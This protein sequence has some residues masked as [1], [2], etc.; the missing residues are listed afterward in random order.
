MLPVLKA[1]GSISCQAQSAKPLKRYGGLGKRALPIKLDVGDEQ[2]VEQMV[3]QTLETFGRIDVLVNN[4]AIAF[5]APLRDML[6][7]KWDTVVK[8]V[9]RGSFLCCRGVLPTMMEQKS[10][11]IVNISSPA[12]DMNGPIFV[13]LAYC[14]AKAGLERLTNG[15]AD[16]V[17]P[18]NITV[19]AIKPRREV[20]TDGMRA[21]NP[22]A[23]Y[24]TWDRP[25]DF[26]LPGILFLAAQDA[27]KITGKV[28]VDEA[29]C[30]EH[31][32]S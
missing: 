4:A 28:F 32:L 17:K 14:A 23:D 25:E 1:R 30:R 9:L 12:A 5:Y 15:L 2:S 6:P 20:D 18:Y 13:G 21:W 19:N 8:V 11:S 29:L 26:M 31:N 10:G 27:T 24:T 22:K 7:K 16:E 3:N